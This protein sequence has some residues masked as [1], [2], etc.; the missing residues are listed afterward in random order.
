MKTPST[1]DC[2]Y[3][4]KG[5]WMNGSWHKSVP[6]GSVELACPE[7]TAEELLQTI[8]SMGFHAVLGYSAHGGPTTP[9]D[10]V[11]RLIKDAALKGDADALRR[12]GEIEAEMGVEQ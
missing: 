6:L 12:L 8:L 11:M 3:Y 9:P 2:V 1:P 10:G 4:F 5:G 7:R